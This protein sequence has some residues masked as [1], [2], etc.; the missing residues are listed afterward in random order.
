MI[1]D[2]GYRIVQLELSTAPTAF[3]LALLRQAV[4][5]A[6]FNKK[7]A[8]LTMPKRYPA[9]LEMTIEG[10]SSFLNDFVPYFNESI[11]KIANDIDPGNESLQL[12]AA[13]IASQLN[14][15]IVDWSDTPTITLA[16]RGR[17]LA[18]MTDGDSSFTQIG[19]E[20]DIHAKRIRDELARYQK[21]AGPRAWKRRHDLLPM[22]RIDS[23]SLIVA[24]RRLRRGAEGVRRHLPGSHLLETLREFDQKA[25]HLIDLRNIVEHID[26]YSIGRGRHDASGLEP[27]D[28]FIL[29]ISGERVTITARRRTVDVLSIYDACQ[30][31]IKCLSTAI[32]HHMI[33]Y[34]FPPIAD[35]D[36]VAYTE[37]GKQIIARSDESAE[38]AEARSLIASTMSRSGKK[39]PARRCTECKHW[40]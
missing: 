32:D 19:V 33:T 40:L 23:L 9:V 20:L 1:G 2:M 5:Y 38:H 39:L 27:G 4:A 11:N 18:Q 36:F 30:S 25:P 7:D 10:N 34:L 29:D 22:L 28:V 12:I 31:L 3:E 15:Q 37:T 16:R 6:R 35:F 26:E 17:E 21:A 8:F 13:S 24:A 14:E